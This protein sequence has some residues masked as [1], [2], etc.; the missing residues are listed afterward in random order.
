L[1]DL[2]S[3]FAECNTSL[4][5]NP[6]FWLRLVGYGY[7]CHDLVTSQGSGLGFEAQSFD[8]PQL[9]DGV[10]DEYIR[11]SVAQFEGVYQSVVAQGF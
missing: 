6:I 2:A 10:G 9:L 8:V 4:L 11:M 7:A 1:H 3:I 5:E